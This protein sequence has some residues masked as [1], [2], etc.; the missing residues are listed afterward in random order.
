MEGVLKKATPEKRAALM[1]EH[2]LSGKFDGNGTMK[3][4]FAALLDRRA[5]V[6]QTAPDGENGSPADSAGRTGSF[7]RRTAS[8]N[9]EAEQVAK[10][11]AK[12][13][14]EQFTDVDSLSR[15]GQKN[16]RDVKRVM[17]VFRDISDGA[18]GEFVIAKES[19]S[20]NAYYDPETGYTVIGADA[21]ENGINVARKGVQSWFRTALHEAAHG[22]EG[23]ASHVKLS[24]ILRHIGG[25]KYYT[26][27]LKQLRSRG[28]WN[29]KASDI[30]AEVEKI[31]RQLERGEALTD[32]QTAFAE[33]F[34]F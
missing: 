27:M 5:T 4:D 25:G 34:N 10:V 2:G 14:R 23:T 20:D 6:G 24:A 16:L 29:G 19:V 18:V 21:L 30:R 11:L 32:K 31:A 1:E 28:Y 17:E 13:G 9:A 33:D 12:E 3:A 8:V 22:G 15:E 26:E 7:D